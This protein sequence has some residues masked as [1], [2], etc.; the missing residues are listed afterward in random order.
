MFWGCFL[1]NKKGPFYI[2][3]K[4]TTAEKRAAAIDLEARNAE[5]EPQNREIWELETAIRCINIT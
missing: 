1:Y 5:I 3:K 4:E 2:W